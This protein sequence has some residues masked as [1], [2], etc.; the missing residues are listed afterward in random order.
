M[1]VHEIM[2]LT[3]AAKASSEI[4][5]SMVTLAPWFETWNQPTML[6]MSEARPMATVVAVAALRFMPPRVIEATRRTRIAPP[7]RISS[8]MIAR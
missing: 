8:G 7:S 6:A 5:L 3:K 4:A 2:M 1:S